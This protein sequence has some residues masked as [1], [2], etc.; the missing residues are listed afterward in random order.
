MNIKKFKYILFISRIYIEVKDI[1]ELEL[2][3]CSD[4]N[5]KLLPDT[6]E[7]KLVIDAKDLSLHT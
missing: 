6:P 7:G 1:V 4:I 2:A 3:V 5:T